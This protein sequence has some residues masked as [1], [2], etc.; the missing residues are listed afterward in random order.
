MRKHEVP[1]SF[2]HMLAQRPELMNAFAVMPRE[3]KQ[4]VW[5]KANKAK[6]KGE[7]QSIVDSIRIK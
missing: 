6:S 2:G 5:D 1:V 3:E 4:K 7:L